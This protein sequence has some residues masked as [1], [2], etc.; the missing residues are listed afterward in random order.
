MVISRQAGWEKR[1]DDEMILRLKEGNRIN[2]FHNGRSEIHLILPSHLYLIYRIPCSQ[3]N[4][5]DFILYFLPTPNPD[6]GLLRFCAF[7]IA[8]LLLHL[9]FAT[10]N[11]ACKFF[12][13]YLSLSEAEEGIKSVASSG[14]LNIDSCARKNLISTSV[15]QQA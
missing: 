11:R 2:S 7:S 3:R 12:L 1:E 10:H 9:T 5:A 8:G 6:L 4:Q 15:M 14:Q 13:A